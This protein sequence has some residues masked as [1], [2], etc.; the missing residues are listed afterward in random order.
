MQ[1]YRKILG[2]LLLL[3][4]PVPVWFSYLDWSRSGGIFSNYRDHYTE[5]ALYD[6]LSLAGLVLAGLLGVQM[7][8]IN[9]TLGQRIFIGILYSITATGILFFLGLLTICCP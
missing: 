2:W 9:A 4:V 3:I 8:L 7:A 6:Q 1:I 5:L